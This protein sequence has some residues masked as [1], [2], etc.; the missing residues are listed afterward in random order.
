LLGAREDVAD[1]PQIESAGGAVRDWRHMSRAQGRRT[2]T[3]PCVFRT[4]LR[5][6]ILMALRPTSAN[7]SRPRI[8]LAER[9]SKCSEGRKAA[10]ARVNGCAGTGKAGGNR[11]RLGH[12][13]SLPPPWCR[14]L[15]ARVG[16][17]V[18][19]RRRLRVAGVLRG[20]PSWGGRR[21]RMERPQRVLRM[22]E[23]VWTG[24]VGGAWIVVE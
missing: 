18:R 19:G 9:P 24:A 17:V 8:K 7:L 2:P 3:L 14:S 4:P 10:W 15:G 6:Y 22:R 20:S 12:G 5:H 21:R 16:L 11:V 1:N 13:K 23:V